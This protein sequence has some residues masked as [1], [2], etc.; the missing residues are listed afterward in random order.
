VGKGTHKASDWLQSAMRQSSPTDWVLHVDVRK[1]FY[2]IDRDILCALL[3]KT[4]KCA[5]TLDLMTMFSYRPDAT[6]V[7]IGNLLSQ[8]FANV[9]LNSLDHFCKRTLKV[10]RYARYMDD[11]IMIAP[12]LAT[13]REWLHRIR[14]HLA[15]LNL[16]ISHYSL[17][18]IKRGANFVGFR[19]WRRG[20]FVRPHVISSF[21]RSAK[22]EDIAGVISRLGHAKKTCSHESMVNYLKDKHA[23]IHLQIQKTTK[24]VDRDRHAL[25]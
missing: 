6:G 7:P 5:K 17:Q 14:E 21:R 20:R 2:S 1:F 8:T 4:I 9:Y 10:R 24:R 18:P 19:T 13:G 3:S 16:E 23:H 12:D 25:P 15:G 22:R 11:S